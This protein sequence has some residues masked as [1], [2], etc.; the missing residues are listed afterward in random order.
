MVNTKDLCVLRLR[1]RLCVL[2]VLS[3]VSLKDTKVMVSLLCLTWP[4]LLVI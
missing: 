3:L 2:L 4:G 1:L